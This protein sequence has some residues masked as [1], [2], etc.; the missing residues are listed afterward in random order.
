MFVI[1]DLVRHVYKLDEY[2]LALGFIV[3]DLIHFQHHELVLVVFGPSVIKLK[4][5]VVKFTST[6]LI[7]KLPQR[8]S[9]ALLKEITFRFTTV[10]LIFILL[11]RINFEKLIIKVILLGMEQTLEN[12]IHKCN[13][14]VLDHNNAFLKRFE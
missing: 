1:Q 3:F 4:D 13:F 14:S 2:F 8:Y 6:L 12:G 5:L 7:H 11:F 9:S 10:G